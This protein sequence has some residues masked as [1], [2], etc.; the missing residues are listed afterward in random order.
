MKFLSL[1]PEC[2]PVVDISHFT[3]GNRPMWFKSALNSNYEHNHNSFKSWP[4]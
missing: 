1:Y 3:S 2:V 4:I